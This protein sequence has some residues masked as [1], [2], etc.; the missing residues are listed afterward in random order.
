MMGNN[1]VG[2]SP[3]R[4]E[5]HI[6]RSRQHTPKQE[7]EGLMANSSRATALENSSVDFSHSILSKTS[8][9]IGDHLGGVGI[10]RVGGRHKKEEIW[11]YM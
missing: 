8:F 10:G 11:R 9:F 3:S 7:R 6:E 1:W 4:L 2:W 5:K